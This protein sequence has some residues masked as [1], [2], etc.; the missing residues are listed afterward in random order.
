M[1]LIGYIYCHVAHPM[2][3]GVEF[4]PMRAHFEKVSSGAA[5]LLAFERVDLEFPFYWHYHPEFELTLIVDSHGQRLVGDGIADYG[6]GDLVLLGPNLPHSWRS[7]PVHLST[8]SCHRAVVVQFREDF[9]GKPFFQLDEMETIVRLLKRSAS[10]LAFGHAANARALAQKI[11]EFPR[12]TPARRIIRLLDVLLDLAEESHAKVL[13][14]DRVRPMCR[15][16]DQQR[17]EQICTYLNERFEEEVN[18]LE[19]ARR[20][21]MD[22]ASLCRFFKRATGRTM[23]A[24]V[25][26]MRVGAAAQLLTDTDLSILEIGFKVGFGNYSNFN[27]Q[28]KRIKGYGPRTLR[29][30]FLSRD[31]AQFAAPL[32]SSGAMRTRRR[33]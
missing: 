31:G 4:A 16:E 33:M 18:Y 2:P 6:P 21:H 32:I 29:Q 10:G 23:T 15:V 3:T 25:N 9:L 7:G 22:Q 12:L 27:R 19:I 13:S 17:I 1:Y 11:V 26:E 5:S 14:T 30:Q 24:Y 28:F 20:V 8:E